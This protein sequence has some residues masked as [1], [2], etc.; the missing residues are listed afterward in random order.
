MSKYIYEMVTFKHV[1]PGYHV[2][3]RYE[4]F[5]SSRKAALSYIKSYIDWALKKKLIAEALEM[6]Y[7]SGSKSTEVCWQVLTGDQLEYFG[8]KRHMILNNYEC[9]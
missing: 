6:E 5:F 3:Y 4:N 9:Y 1:E 7:I 2:D 8:I